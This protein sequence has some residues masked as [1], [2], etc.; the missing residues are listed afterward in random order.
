MAPTINKMKLVATTMATF[1]STD[2]FII[3]LN[4]GGNPLPPFLIFLLQVDFEFQRVDGCTAREVRR[5]K[6]QKGR[7]KN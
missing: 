3:S 5:K 6:R 2:R 1:I 7:R 4:Y